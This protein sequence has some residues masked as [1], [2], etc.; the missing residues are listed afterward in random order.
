MVTIVLVYLSYESQPASNC[1]MYSGPKTEPLIFVTWRAVLLHKNNCA[2]GENNDVTQDDGDND[3]EPLSAAEV[4]DYCWVLLQTWRHGYLLRNLSLGISKDF[5]HLD[6][7][8]L[9][10]LVC[11]VNIYIGWN[12]FLR[13][14]KCLTRFCPIVR[15]SPRRRT[16]S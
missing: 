10:K 8:H 3:T 4:S 9:M 12:W 16:E 1:G 6:S 15:H 7:L 5:H 13:T 11:Y 2:I 14:S